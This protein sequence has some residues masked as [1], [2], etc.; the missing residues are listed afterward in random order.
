MKI[1]LDAKRAYHNFTGLGNYSRTLITDLSFYFPENEYFLFNT[2][3][4]SRYYFT[5]EN[6]REVLPTEFLSRKLP[7][8]WRSRWMVNDLLNLNID[9]YHGL[10]HEIPIGLSNTSIKTIVSIHDLIFER[11]P[12]QYKAI[13][14]YVYRR[15]FNYACQ[16][17][18]RIIAISEQTKADIIEYYNINSNKID[19]CYQSCDPSFN[20]TIS[21]EEKK[22]VSKKYNLP[23]RFFLSVGSI[24]ERKNLLN[25][26]KALKNMGQD[27]IPLVVV[28]QGKGKYRE[29]VRE[30]I[31]RN[32]MSKQVIFLS[33]SYPHLAELP[34][35]YS[36]AKALL[37]PSHYEGFGIPV[38]EGL[39]VGIPV[40]T[41]NVSC[42][43]EAGGPAALY[44]NPEKPEE[45]ATAMLRVLHDKELVHNMV[46]K[47]F[48]HTKKFSNKKCITK[49]MES[50]QRVLQS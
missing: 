43:P 30:F 28:G 17:A 1:A 40:I 23:P 2:N 31:K 38:L 41:S 35:V 32:N 26:C 6:L 34:V 39:S 45:I 16:H 10:S 48:I 18:D 11:Y 29:L 8:L 24:I 37:Y 49:V 44:V 5:Q 46:E 22:A 36:L 9:L 20:S 47:G 42:L 25:V 14:V 12:H 4:S 50:Y 15:K 7:S 3:E 13:D 19:V 21:E 33:E 27:A